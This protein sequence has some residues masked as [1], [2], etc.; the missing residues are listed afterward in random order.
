ME[1]S[2]ADGTIFELLFRLCIISLVG[3][4]LYKEEK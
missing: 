2:S 1:I 4:I 3:L